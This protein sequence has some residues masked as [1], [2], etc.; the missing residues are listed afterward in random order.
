MVS[1]SKQL[2]LQHASISEVP[3]LHQILVACSLDMKDRFQYGSVKL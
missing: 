3:S 1:D 2:C